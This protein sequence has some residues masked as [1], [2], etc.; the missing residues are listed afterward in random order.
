MQCCVHLQQAVHHK[1]PKSFWPKF[2]CY[3]SL[4]N[5]IIFLIA[6][7]LVFNCFGACCCLIAMHHTNVC[8]VPYMQCCMQLQVQHVLDH[9]LCNMQL[10]NSHSHMILNERMHCIIFVKFFLYFL[11]YY[12]LHCIVLCMQH[13]HCLLTRQGCCTTANLDH[14]TKQTCFADAKCNYSPGN[15]IYL[16]I[17][18]FLAR[19][20]GSAPLRIVHSLVL[21]AT[22]LVPRLQLHCCIQRHSACLPASLATNLHHFSSTY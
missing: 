10:V 3:Y 19:Q 1:A 22:K 6:F 9:A 5:I 17:L 18:H 14:T 12:C 7:V 13:L 4:F 11:Y 8:V 2:H 15:P 16:V 20:S 21:L